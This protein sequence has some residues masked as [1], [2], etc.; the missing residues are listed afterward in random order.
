MKTSQNRTKGECVGELFM[1]TRVKF[2]IALTVV[3][4]CASPASARCGLLSWMG[5]DACKGP[6]QPK[7][8]QEILANDLE[9]CKAHLPRQINACLDGL[10]KRRASEAQ[11]EA[12]TAARLQALG[13]SLQ[14]AGAALQAASG[15]NLTS[16]FFY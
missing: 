13:D 3:V 12:A 2:V 7:S 1:F 9:W 15:I 8:T 10:T 11:Q 4:I 6:F 16:R 14:S 5:D